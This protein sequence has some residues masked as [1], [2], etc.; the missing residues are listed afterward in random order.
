MTSLWWIRSP[1]LASHSLRWRVATYGCLA[2]VVL[3]INVVVTA[4]APGLNHA[5]LIVRFSDGSTIVRCVAFGEDTITGLQLLERCGLDY[6]LEGQAVCRIETVGCQAEDCF[7]KCRPGSGSCSYWSYQ[8]WRD[9]RWVF[10]GAGAG[11]HVVRDGDIDGWSWGTPLPPVTPSEVCDELRISPAPPTVEAGCSELTV[12][13]RFQGDAN[14]NA[15]VVARIRQLGSPWPEALLELNRQDGCFY[16]AWTE[17]QAGEHEV[18][19]MVLDPDGVRGS[20]HWGST[21]TIGTAASIQ[22]SA[23]EAWI[24]Q[25]LSFTDTSRG[26]PATSRFWDWGDGQVT[27]DAPQVHHS[28]DAAGAYQVRM[29][30]TNPCGSSSAA[31]T[32]RIQSLVVNIP[33]A[34]RSRE[35][36]DR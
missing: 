31:M 19:V 33:W 25:T 32:I 2:A 22:A 9:G 24:H 28:Y 27:T 23:S 15:A 14:G 29:T 18:Q 3:L 5:G 26:L 16:G 6:E 20:D 34:V 35:Q 36:D 11:S 21:A 12:A 30:S 4:Q 13:L 10:A 17:L 8:H 1:Q 7:C